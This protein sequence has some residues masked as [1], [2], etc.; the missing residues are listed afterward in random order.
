MRRT[1]VEETTDFK[2]ATKKVIIV[3]KSVEASPD[4]RENAGEAP[5]ANK[6]AL[7]DFGE[8]SERASSHTLPVLGSSWLSARFS[9]CMEELSSSK[10]SSSLSMLVSD[11]IFR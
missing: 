11:A 3:L 4:W 8:V 1:E 7:R 2:T 5:K 6:H 9:F 10:L